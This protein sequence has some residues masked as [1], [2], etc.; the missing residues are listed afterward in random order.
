MFNGRISFD[1]IAT[2]KNFCSWILFPYGSQVKKNSDAKFRF[3][4]PGFMATCG[5]SDFPGGGRSRRN[6]LHG[7]TVLL[8]T[9][10][11][12]ALYVAT[13]GLVEVQHDHGVGLFAVPAMPQPHANS[14]HKEP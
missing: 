1:G 4:T 14:A 3:V 5:E 7:L 10:T 11:K 9:R 2:V 8:L 6:R 12:P 13:S